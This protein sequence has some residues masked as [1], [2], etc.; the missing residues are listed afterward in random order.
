MP[1]PQNSIR[2][3]G[4]LIQRSKFRQLLSRLGVVP[5]EAIWFGVNV[6]NEL[7]SNCDSCFV[8]HSLCG[9]WKVAV[10]IADEHKSG[11]LR[12]EILAKYHQEVA[13]MHIVFL[14]ERTS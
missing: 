4:S 5:R 9:D 13:I 7:A 11:G 14:I 10:H 2:T 12:T 1:P 6:G 3:G 8:G